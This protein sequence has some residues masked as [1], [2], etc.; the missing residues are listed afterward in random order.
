[1]SLGLIKHQAMETYP[2]LN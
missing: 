1:M 2:T